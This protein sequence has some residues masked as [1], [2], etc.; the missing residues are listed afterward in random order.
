VAQ[1]KS[2]ELDG[3]VKKN[4]GNVSGGTPE[5]LLAEMRRINNDLRAKPGDPAKG[6]IVF[7]ANCAQCHQ[8]FGEGNLVGPELTQANRMDTEYMLGSMVNPNMVVRKEYV[9]FAVET[10]DGGFYNGLIS[11]RS[12]GSVTLLNAN[13]VKTTIAT[14]DIET[15]EEA[16]LSL[17][18]EG[19]LTP[20]SP[21]DV[22]DLFAYLQL[23]DPLPKN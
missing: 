3:L 22:R 23:K 20:L 16:G 21:D 15:I 6:K 5:F 12:P 18:P 17:M 11:E 13:S 2:E 10:K 4:W 19:I 1:H 14:G 7:T 8:I 9:Q